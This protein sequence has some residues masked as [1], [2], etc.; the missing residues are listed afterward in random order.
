MGVVRIVGWVL[1]GL[2]L[3]LIGAD[4]ISTLEADEAVIRSGREVLALFGV[5]AGG[6]EAGGLSGA[7]RAVLG[8]PFWALLGGIG[9]I[10]I[11][12]ARPVD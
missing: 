3:A 9:L 5:E 1:F 10:L 8:V 4:G 7:V 2:G 12:T 11:L 6:G